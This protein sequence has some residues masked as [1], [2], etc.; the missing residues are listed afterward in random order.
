L[1]EA[2]MNA[3]LAAVRQTLKEMGIGLAATTA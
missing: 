2:D 1:F 3:L